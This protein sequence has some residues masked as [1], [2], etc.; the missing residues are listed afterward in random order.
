VIRVTRR[1]RFPASHRLHTPA[2]S[3]EANR[4]LYGKCNNP[5]GHGH[6]Y[7]LE[8]T[9]R[10]PVEAESGLAV[11]VGALD[12]LVEKRVLNE[13]RMS[14]LNDCE[15]FAGGR[16]PT[17]ENLASEIINRLKEGW[18]EAFDGEWPVLEKVRIRETRRNTFETMVNDS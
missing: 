14:Y 9:A 11:R 13:F 4:E 18:G 6:D 2:L 8:V 3:E 15:S 10:G 1:Y 7:V 12:G 16:V 5:F 17:T